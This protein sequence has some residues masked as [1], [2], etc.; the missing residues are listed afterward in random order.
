M[1]LREDSRI[2]E[3]KEVVMDNEEEAVCRFI[4]IL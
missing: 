1:N 4:L 3:E 2:N